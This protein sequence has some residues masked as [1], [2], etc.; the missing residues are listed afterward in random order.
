MRS[1]LDR[2]DSVVKRKIGGAS[3]AEDCKRNEAMLKLL[4]DPAEDTAG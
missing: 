3:L 1:D 2:G 4:A